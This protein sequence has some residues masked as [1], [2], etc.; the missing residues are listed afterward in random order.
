MNQNAAYNYF[1][2][3][4]NEALMYHRGL[5][6][7]DIGMLRYII[8]YAQENHFLEGLV[9]RIHS[10]TIENCKSYNKQETLELERDITL[11]VG[12]NAGGKSNTMDILA[13]ILRKFFLE[14][15]TINESRSDGL[16]FHDIVKERPFRPLSKFLDKNSNRASDDPNIQLVLEIGTTDMSNISTILEKR[17]EFESALAKYRNKPVSAL[18]FLNSWRVDMFTS[19]QTVKYTIKNENMVAGEEIGKKF[20][21]YLQ[22]LNL[23]MLLARDLHDIDLSPTILYFSP[24]RSAIPED[25]N[26]TLAEDNYFNLLHNYFTTTSSGIGRSTLYRTIF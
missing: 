13:I 5:L 9:M 8:R 17:S 22:Y 12:P 2:L 19:G 23:F 18:T 10:M 11:L 15:Y 14:T 3:I 4:P 25:L 16:L 26:A 21:E 20:Q 7:C 6:E 24:Y 1:Q